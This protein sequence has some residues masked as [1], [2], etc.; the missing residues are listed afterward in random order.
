MRRSPRIS[1]SIALVV[2]LMTVAAAHSATAMTVRE[3]RLLVLVNDYR[4]RHGLPRLRADR[5]VTYSAHRHSLRMAQANTLF[6]TSDLR[7]VVGSGATCGG[8]NIAK[9]R[10]VRSIFRLWAASAPHRA[11]MLT[12]CYRRTG[13]GI[14]RARGYL[15][16]TIIFYG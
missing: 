3:H 5:D 9:A 2:I 15:W 14:V 4:A 12:T 13:V 1:L 7:S 10:R 8:E 11:N 6:H 16:A